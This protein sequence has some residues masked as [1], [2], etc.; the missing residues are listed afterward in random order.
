MIREDD[1]LRFIRMFVAFLVFIC[2][3]A[4]SGCSNSNYSIADILK[5]AGISERTA[6]NMTVELRYLADSK[7]SNYKY[8]DLNGNSELLKH[9]LRCL[10]SGKTASKPQ[11]EKFS[12]ELKSDFEIVFSDTSGKSYSFFYMSQRN[13]LIYPKREGKKGGET[14]RYFYYSPDKELISLIQGQIQYAKMKESN[15]VKPFRNMEEL[16]ASIDPDELAEEGTELSF[17]FFTDTTPENTGTACHIYTNAECDAVAK[18]CYLV[19]AYSKS[20]GGKQE[21]LSIVGMEVNSNYT[22]IILTQ[23]DDA[24]DSVETGESAPES[25]A[26]SIQ[27]E[28]VDPAK[29]I[30]FVDGDNNIID[31]I[32]PE[33]IA[34][35]SSGSA[36]STI[37]PSPYVASSVAA[38][39][40]AATTAPQETDP[41][42]GSTD[43]P[44]DGD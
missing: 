32:L 43:D 40:V 16:K 24:L 23:A 17:E 20:K 31:V 6:T 15:S 36:Q 35:A 28:E 12:P 33:D 39:A 3:V 25:F 7:G 27:K 18:D 41:F 42:Q 30:V 10:S 34:S 22:K 5:Q 19:T 38:T 4:F 11:D 8:V 44:G 14:L 9:I 1:S 21:K 13:L 37:N 26:A 2:P 29:W